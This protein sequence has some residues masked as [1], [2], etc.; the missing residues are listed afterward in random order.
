MFA[1]SA[2]ARNEARNE[3]K[4]PGYLAYHDYTFSTEL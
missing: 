2:P 1:Y 4:R 3:A